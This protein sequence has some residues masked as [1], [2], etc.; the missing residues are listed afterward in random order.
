MMRRREMKDN[1]YCYKINNNTKVSGYFKIYQSASGNIML[2]MADR[3][4][5]L[6]KKQINELGIDIYSLYDFDYDKY[7]NTE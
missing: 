3:Y 7:K 5:K 6:T 4:T 2:L 1:Y